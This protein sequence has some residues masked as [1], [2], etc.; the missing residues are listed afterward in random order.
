VDGIPGLGGALCANGRGDHRRVRRRRYNG[1]E[2][3]SRPRLVWA[4]ATLP[5]TKLPT[6][7]GEYPKMFRQLRDR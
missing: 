2:L 4:Y 7:L 3:T 5:R 1:C 6:S